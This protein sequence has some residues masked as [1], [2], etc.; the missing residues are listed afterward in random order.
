MAKRWIAGLIYKNDPDN[1]V[2]IH[3]DEFVE[4]G[5]EIERGPDWRLIELI[6]IE[7]NTN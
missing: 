7:L 5:D 4:F 6:K 3:F 2:T 1:V